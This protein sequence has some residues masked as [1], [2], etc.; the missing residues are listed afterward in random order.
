MHLINE[1]IDKSIDEGIDVAVRLGSL[2]DSRLCASAPATPIQVL[3][4]P[5]HNQPN[6][7]RE[8]TKV[9]AAAFENSCSLKCLRKGSGFCSISFKVFINKSFT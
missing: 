1:C 5:S 3:F 4:P 8:F 9:L 7:V 2:F 6:R